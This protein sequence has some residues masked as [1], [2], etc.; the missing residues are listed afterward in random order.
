MRYQKYHNSQ[1]SKARTRC[2]HFDLYRQHTASFI[3]PNS[4]SQLW[5]RVVPINNEIHAQ[6][7]KIKQLKHGSFVCY[8]IYPYLLADSSPKIAHEAFGL[9]CYFWWLNHKLVRINPIKHTLNHT[10]TITYCIYHG[11]LK[12]QRRHQAC[13][14]YIYIY[15][16]EFPCMYTGVHTGEFPTQLQIYKIHLLFWQ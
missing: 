6:M 13:I 1:R 10:L 2:K 15:S 5:D 12:D 11:C 3:P 16:R 14:T 4:P 8:R 7:Y 9:V